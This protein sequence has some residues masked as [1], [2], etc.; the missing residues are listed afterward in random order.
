M[1]GY[2]STLKFGVRGIII[3][4]IIHKD[5]SSNELA[6][7]GFKDSALGNDDS[8]FLFYSRCINMR[9]MILKHAT[10]M[11]QRVDRTVEKCSA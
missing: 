2:Q 6:D 1:R 4:S 11:V 8:L 10:S 9:G 3:K 5:V 7:C